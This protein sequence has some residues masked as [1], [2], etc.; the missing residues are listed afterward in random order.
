[1]VR[2]TSEQ[3]RPQALPR[4][5]EIHSYVVTGAPGHRRLSCKQLAKRIRNHWGIENRLHHVLDRTFGEDQQRCRTGDGPVVLSLLRKIV[6]AVL[7]N[8]LPPRLA[9][10]S[11]PEARQIL[12]ARPK[13]TARL[14]TAPLV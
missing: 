4:E 14:I 6:V 3:R 1:M 11:K 5:T 13:I 12:E 2:V 8:H 9:Q 7:E 10:V